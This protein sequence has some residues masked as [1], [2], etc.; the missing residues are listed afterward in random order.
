MRLA[1][2]PSA[3]FKLWSVQSM[4]NLYIYS[5]TVHPT[6]EPFKLLA[7]ASVVKHPQFLRASP[8]FFIHE[9]GPQSRTSQCTFLKGTLAYC[10]YKLRTCQASAKWRQRVKKQAI[11]LY[12]KYMLS[13]IGRV[14]C[15]VS[16]HES[17]SHRIATLT[18]NKSCSLHIYS[19]ASWTVGLS[20]NWEPCHHLCLTGAS[21]SSTYWSAANIPGMQEFGT[22]AK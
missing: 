19:S 4:S 10:H 22:F 6:C 20:A 7:A 3:D 12:P 1:F 11:L 2:Y 8:C 16:L 13:T 21:A 14:W 18:S 17:D 9:L 5:Y 15:S